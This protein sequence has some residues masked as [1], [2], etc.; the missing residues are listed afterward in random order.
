MVHIFETF[1]SILLLASPFLM[2]AAGG[3]PEALLFVFDQ[4]LVLVGDPPGDELVHWGMGGLGH[5]V[6]DPDEGDAV[7][8]EHDHVEGQRPTRLATIG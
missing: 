7:E 4:R 2:Y 6:D 3:W 5:V 1:L 8:D